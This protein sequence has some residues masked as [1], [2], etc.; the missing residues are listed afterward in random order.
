MDAEG[1][2][3][4]PTAGQPS[5]AYPLHV[6]D[7]WRQP[8]PATVVGDVYV[9]PGPGE[10][11]VIPTRWRGR[12]LPDGRL[13]VMGLEPV[14]EL[15]SRQ[16]PRPPPGQPYFAPCNALEQR[17]AVAFRAVLKVEEVGVQDDFFALGGRGEEAVELCRRLGAA[18][19]LVFPQQ[20][21]RLSTIATLAPV[22]EAQRGLERVPSIAGVEVAAPPTS[23][24]R[25]LLAAALEEPSRGL[26]HA[27]LR[28]R[29]G[30]D[31]A[32]LTAALTALALWH[33]ALR[34]GYER[35]GSLW[36]GVCGPAAPP[37]TLRI[38]DLSR[39][40]ANERLGSFLRA[41]HDAPRGPAPRRSAP[42]RA[43]PRLGGRL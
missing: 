18:N 34:L 35:D 19:L 20:I 12:W 15:K 25:A 38:V 8:V 6:L 4:G 26:T 36:H 13:E 28:Y 30:L 5:G 42:R 1:D 43:R 23:L 29:G 9:T 16:A 31:S 32:A 2:T 11:E 33:D 40:P 37:P 39:R 17:L 24:Q 14:A 22:V 3:P 27:I 21:E 7:R 41:V 10:Q